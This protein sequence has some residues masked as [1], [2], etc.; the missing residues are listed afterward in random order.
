M[1]LPSIGWD[2]Y[3]RSG[4]GYLQGRF[5]GENIVYAESEF[6]YRIKPN[7]LLG[8]VIFINAITADNEFIDQKLFDRFAIGYGAGLRIKMNKETRTNIC[9]DIGLGQNNSSGIYFG[10]QEA[11]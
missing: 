8:G 9:V 5:R 10:I 3:N 6:R 4:R 11:F 7:G 1:A 2:T